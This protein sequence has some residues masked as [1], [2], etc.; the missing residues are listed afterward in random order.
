MEPGSGIP[1][2]IPVCAT[3]TVS[4][5]NADGASAL[6]A[7]PFFMFTFRKGFEPGIFYAL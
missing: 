7:K 6:R 4:P 2:M 5:V 1:K 3:H